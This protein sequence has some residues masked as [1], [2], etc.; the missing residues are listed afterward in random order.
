[1]PL[2]FD[3]SDKLKEIIAALQRKDRH[4]LE[5][6]YKKIK[7]IINSDEFTI[8]HYKNLR[9]DMKEFKRVHINSSFVLTF[10][11]DKTDKS[12]LFIDFDH[13]DRIYK[14]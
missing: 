1:M 5:L 2:D 14:K 3:F 4:R 10:K 7:Q 8:D 13:H 9:H 6:L 11:F 12:V